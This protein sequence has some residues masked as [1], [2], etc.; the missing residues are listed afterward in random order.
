MNFSALPKYI[1]WVSIVFD[2]KMRQ[3]S[4]QKPESGYHSE[5]FEY[6][7]NDSVAVNVCVSTCT[8]GILPRALILLWSS[9]RVIFGGFADIVT[10]LAGLKPGVPSRRRRLLSFLPGKEFFKCLELRLLFSCKNQPGEKEILWKEVSPLPH[11]YPTH[12]S[13]LLHLRV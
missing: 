10:W 11:G 5:V 3:M 7:D 6:V 9:E 1:Y 13:E 2:S 12:H 4:N 8:C